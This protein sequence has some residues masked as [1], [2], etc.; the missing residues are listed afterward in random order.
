[1]VE[2]IFQH[3]CERKVLVD[4]EDCNGNKK[5][6]ENRDGNRPGR[7]SCFARTVAVWVILC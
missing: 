6:D 7:D 4:E 2:E 3:A 1:M 5:N